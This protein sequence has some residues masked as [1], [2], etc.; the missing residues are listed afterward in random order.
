M[1]RRAYIAMASAA[2][3]GG[4]GG[5][6]PLLSD[7]GRSNSNNGSGSGQRSS[8]PVKRVGEVKTSVFRQTILL[9][10]RSFNHIAR[11]PSLLGLTF[12]F[13]LVAAIVLG[14]VFY[15]ISSD[16]SGSQDRAGFLFFLVFFFA[17]LS[18]NSLNVW[19][20]QRVWCSWHAIAP[21]TDVSYGCLFVTV[22]LG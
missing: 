7:S 8:I 6:A 9:S 5:A 17:L 18:L 15:Q 4:G 14:I 1:I 16:L 10:A 22:V 12:F 20:M 21:L 2:S 3:M 11:D 19:R 13:T